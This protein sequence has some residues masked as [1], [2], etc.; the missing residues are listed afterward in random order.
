MHVNGALV[1]ETAVNWKTEYFLR[2]LDTHGVGHAEGVP[3][4][5]F[6][7]F[8]Y[9]CAQCGHIM[10]KRISPNHH[11]NV[12]FGNYT[13]INQAAPWPW[14]KFGLAVKLALA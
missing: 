8:F 13:C 12:D 4:D 9:A 7:I 6:K 5:I 3:E 2:H 14:S 10:T 1:D 11:E